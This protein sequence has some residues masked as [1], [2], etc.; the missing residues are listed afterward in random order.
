MKDI[1]RIQS[2]LD[3]ARAMLLEASKRIF[4][5]DKELSEYKTKSN[6]RVKLFFCFEKGQP[7][8]SHEVV[9]LDDTKSTG[10]KRIIEFCISKQSLEG[11]HLDLWVRKDDLSIKA[12]HNI[13]FSNG[14]V[15]MHCWPIG[16]EINELQAVIQLSY[17]EVQ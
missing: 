9:I 12:T 1:V 5:I 7:K 4:E 15:Y 3:I 16:I 8:E 11:S 13:V 2:E 14:D 10:N 17:G 6:A